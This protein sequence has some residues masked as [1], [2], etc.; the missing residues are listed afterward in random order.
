MACEKLIVRHEWLSD[1][2]TGID[3]FT[4]AEFLLQPGAEREALLAVLFGSAE[5]GRNAEI[6]GELT[7]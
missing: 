2:H 7:P 5:T 4:V 1:R 3:D 6:A